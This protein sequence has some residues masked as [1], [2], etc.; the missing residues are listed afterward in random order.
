MLFTVSTEQACK[1]VTQDLAMSIR[2][3]LCGLARGA[4]D[5]FS[6]DADARQLL[7]RQLSWCRCVVALAGSHVGAATWTHPA[8]SFALG[9]S[10]VDAGFHDLQ[11]VGRVV[12]RTGPVSTYAC[13]ASVWGRLHD[14]TAIRIFFIPEH[15]C[16]GWHGWCSYLPIQSY[17]RNWAISFVSA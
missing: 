1:P 10:R 16:P 6:W 13:V 11:L 3:G 15:L 4:R 7:R 12:H 8:D 2:C 17:S 5:P 9:P 14:Q